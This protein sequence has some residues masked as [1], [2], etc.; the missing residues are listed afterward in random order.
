MYINFFYFYTTF[1][2]HKIM[3]ND[4]KICNI[5]KKIMSGHGKNQKRGF[6]RSVY[7]WYM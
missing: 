6:Q 3:Y 2:Y 1:Y 5:S 4:L 7:S